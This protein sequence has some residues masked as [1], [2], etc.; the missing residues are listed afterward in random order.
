MIIIKLWGGMGNQLFQYAF[1]FVLAKTKGDDLKFD[2]T[3]YDKQPKYVGRRAVISS[4]EFPNLDFQY[5][6]KRS[7]IVSILENRYINHAFRYANG[8]DC[9]IVGQHILIEKLYA[10]YP[11]IPYKVDVVNYYDGYWQSEKYFEKYREEILRLFTPSKTIIAKTEEWRN[12]LKTECCVAV[13]IRRG[14]YVRKGDKDISQGID[15]YLKAMDYMRSH[16]EKPLFCIFSDDLEWCKRQFSEYTDIVYVENRCKNGDLVDMYSMTLCNHGIMS[17][18]TFSWWG[19]WLR[20]DNS[21]SMVIYPDGKY[22]N[23]Y[24]MSDSWHKITTLLHPDK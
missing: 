8:L 14:D 12:T 9:S 24:F 16:L 6:N 1:G 7:N 4:T 11:Q 19:N 13:H 21:K 5:I 20:K 2:I 18:S 17:I 22:F 10:Y 3:F 15:Y 23:E